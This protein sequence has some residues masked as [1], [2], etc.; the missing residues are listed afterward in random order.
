MDSVNLKKP[1][2]WLLLSMGLMASFG[3]TYAQQPHSVP[4]QPAQAQP[5]EC[6]KELLL[7]YFPANYVTATLKKFNVPEDK[8][9]A[10]IA[11]LAAQDKDVLKRVN[12]K[13][14]K[15]SPNPFND[16][17]P[18]QRQIVVKLFRET[19]LQ[20]LGDALKKQGITD[21]NQ[22]KAMSNDIQ[23]QKAENFKQCME[24]QKI[25]LP[26][27]KKEE[28]RSLEH[29]ERTPPSNST[30]QESPS[31]KLLSDSDNGEEDNQNNDETHDNESDDENGSDDHETKEYEKNA[32]ETKGIE[33]SK[34]KY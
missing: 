30:D 32:S 6:T 8:W 2:A 19:L 11:D 23:Q 18:A 13:A 3:T 20:I 7:A 9:S 29:P 22:I 31:E 5:D 1:T 34:T 26:G 4:M 27:F 12:E 21:E 16:R 24:K 33:K 14:S 28:I 17:D 25:P 10:V 15:L